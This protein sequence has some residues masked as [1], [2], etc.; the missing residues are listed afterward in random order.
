MT[1]HTARLYALVGAVL[2]FF[3]A[4]AAIAAHP[5]R[6]Q[7]RPR[8]RQ[9]PRLAALQAREQRL[10]AESL[11]VKQI[12]DRRWAVYRA[13]LALRKQEIAAVQAANAQV[14]A[15]SLGVR[16]PAHRRAGRPLRRRR[17]HALGPRRHA[18]AADDHEDLVMQRRTF[19]A[20]GTEVELL[21]DAEPSA[22]S[23]L[24]LAA[25]RAGVR[26]AGGAALALPPRLRALGAQPLRQPRRRR[27]PR[28]GRPR[29]AVEARERTGGRFDPTVHDALVAAGYDRTFDEVARD[30]DAGPPRACGGRVRVDGDADRARAGLPPRPRR[31]REGLRR[32]PGL[33]APR[34]GPGPAS[35]TR[36]AT[37]PAAGACGP[38]A[39][40]PRD[41]ELTLG[42]ED[43]AL[44]TSGRDRRRWR[45]G[46]REAHHLIDPET[47]APADGDLLRVTVFAGTAVEA[48]VLAK[49]IFLGAPA[50]TPAVLVTADGRT[51]LAGGLG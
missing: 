37:S 29:L 35:S 39:S 23:E 25:G 6:T 42:L 5:W 50:E 16:L 44:A 20:M 2:V 32:R 24:A 9:D 17:G 7:T 1:S 13:Q 30:G 10:R 49:A 38:S 11:A 28:R 21:L 48:E 26:A 14:P 51:V 41:G 40:R 33:R 4:W 15:R 46:G 18:A 45:R 43:G 27:G 31:H 12:V 34:T 19:P 3:V 47:G 8:P 36:A 22:E